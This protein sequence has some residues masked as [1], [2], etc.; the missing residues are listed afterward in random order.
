MTDELMSPNEALARLR[1][2]RPDECL[3]V[4]DNKDFARKKMQ[5]ERAIWHAKEKDTIL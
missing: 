3:W 1:G 2:C 5:Y 4:W